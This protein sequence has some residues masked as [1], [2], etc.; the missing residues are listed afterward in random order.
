[1]ILVTTLKN[2]RG[3]FD[4]HLSPPTCLNDSNLTR[5]FFFLTQ[6]QLYRNHE[7]S[8]GQQDNTTYV[9]VCIL[10]GE[11][12]VT[13]HC[14]SLDSLLMDPADSSLGDLL[15]VNPFIIMTKRGHKTLV[16]NSKN[17][18]MSLKY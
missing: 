2:L 18:L 9:T 14:L 13:S 6:T 16:K 12:Q 1:M 10:I 3:R 8:E 4:L 7:W 5:V 15:A 11:E 17:K